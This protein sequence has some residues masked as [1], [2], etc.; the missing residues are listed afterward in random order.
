MCVC[1]II[2]SIFKSCESHLFWHIF[3]NPN[4]R[5]GS[6]RSLCFKK[7]DFNLEL[8]GC[9]L[10]TPE[11]TIKYFFIFNSIDIFAYCMLQYGKRKY[12]CY[13]ATLMTSY[14]PTVLTDQNIVNGV[15]SIGQPFCMMSIKCL[16]KVKLLLNFN[17]MLS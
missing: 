14:Y 17:K 4:S 15:N 12:T 2:Y 11:W 7:V 3:Y 8:I 10:L 1:Y 9:F 6:I 5:P 16:K 13:L